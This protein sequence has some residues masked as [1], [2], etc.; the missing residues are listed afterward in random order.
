M[1]DEAK[2]KAEEMMIGFWKLIVDTEGNPSVSDITALGFSESWALETII[3]ISQFSPAT[4][5]K[6]IAGAQKEIDRRT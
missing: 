5:K 6:M 3:K 4:V 1:T 2:K